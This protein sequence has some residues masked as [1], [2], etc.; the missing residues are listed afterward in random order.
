MKMIKLSDEM[1]G[2][3]LLLI[4]VLFLYKYAEFGG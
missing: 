3:M 1:Q 2:I 4:E